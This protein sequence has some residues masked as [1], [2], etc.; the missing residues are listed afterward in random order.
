MKKRPVRKYVGAPNNPAGE[1]FNALSEL[2]FENMGLYYSSYRA[3]VAD[4]E[5]PEHLQRLKLIIPVI[6]ELEPF[7]YWAFP[8]GVFYGNGYGTQNIPELG[9]MVWVEFE[10]GRPEIPLWEHGH[11]ARGE[12]PK[13]KDLLDYGA[14]W[15]ITPKGHSVIFNDTKNT[16]QIKHSLGHS[17]LLNDQGISIVKDKTSNISLGSKDKSKYS[18]VLGEP[19]KKILE[20]INKYNGVLAQALISDAASTA[21][22]P[23]LGKAAI[24]TASSSLLIINEQI[25]LLINQLLSNLVTLE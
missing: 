19:L 25:S 6:N 5:D 12:T 16:I 11:P 13:D 24:S 1:A 9:D 7:E 14:K 3:V 17:I 20:Q 22:S 18:A 23:F 10:G 2:G 8:K 4:I 15:F 21:P